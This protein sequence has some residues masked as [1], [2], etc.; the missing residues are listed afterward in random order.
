MRVGGEEAAGDRVAMSGGGERGTFHCHMEQGQGLP[1][2]TATKGRAPAHG[3]N[4]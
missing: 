1:P 4:A 3:Y 2:T